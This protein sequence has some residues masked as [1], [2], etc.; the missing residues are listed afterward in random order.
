[1]KRVLFTEEQLAQCMLSEIQLNGDEQLAQTKD[2]KTA[3][4]NTIDAAQS[5]GVDTQKGVSVGFSADS[6]RTN[7][8]IS[9]ALTKKQLK[10]AKL[11]YLKE[12]S[13]FVRKKDL[14]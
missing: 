13:Y 8:G 6:L 2:L 7:A 5:Q 4:Q 1:M 14:K 12:N 10:E 3:T 11:K 9:E